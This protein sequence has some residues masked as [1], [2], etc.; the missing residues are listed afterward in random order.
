[1]LYIFSLGFSL[2]AGFAVPAGHSIVP[3]IVKKKDLQAGNSIIMG[4]GQLTGFI[5]P[6]AAGIIIGNWAK[7]LSLLVCC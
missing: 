5:G 1:M 4:T 2:V 3:M 7:S 6:F